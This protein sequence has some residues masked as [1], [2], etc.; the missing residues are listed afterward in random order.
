[1]PSNAKDNMKAKEISSDAVTKNTD[2]V[3]AQ[4][5]DKNL[6][7]DNHLDIKNIHDFESLGVFKSW[8]AF[9]MITPDEA[10]CW[11]SSANLE[12]QKRDKTKKT[13]SIMLSIRLENQ[14]RDEF[15]YHS[16]YNLDPDEKLN[17]T[18][19][20]VVGFKLLPQEHWAWL[21]SSIDESRFVLASQKGTTLVLLG[22]TTHDKKFKETYSLSGFTVAYKTA[23]EACS[24]EI[25]KKSNPA[26]QR[27]AQKS[28]KQ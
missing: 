8:E 12:A 11:I 4:L 18:I 26:A 23:F 22:K 20:N 1:M 28:V 10:V 21:K 3:P 25:N 2:S 9:A 13:S 17:M 16:L 24:K 15:S 27:D 14:E 7:K 19:D 5:P 6:P